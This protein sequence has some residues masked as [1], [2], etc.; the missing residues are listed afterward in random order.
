MAGQLGVTG[1]G[2]LLE[3]AE[4]M[5][6]LRYFCN[7]PRCFEII[8]RFILEAPGVWKAVGLLILGDGG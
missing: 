7:W 6:I 4:G 1:E 8:L 3:N 5:Q 2:T